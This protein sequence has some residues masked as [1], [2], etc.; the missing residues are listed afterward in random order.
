MNIFLDLF[1]H[2]QSCPRQIERRTLM[3][4][5]FTYFS[6][7]F[8]MNVSK[9]LFQN[10]EN[11]L[12]YRLNFIFIWWNL[13]KVFPKYL[14]IWK[15]NFSQKQVRHIPLATWS[16]YE[17]H[18][19]EKISIFWNT[20]SEHDIIKPKDPDRYDPSRPLTLHEFRNT[21]IFSF[22]F[23][24]KTKKAQSIDWAFVVLAPPYLP[25]QLPVEYFRHCIA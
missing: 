23:L 24:V 25:G 18:T 14:K 6:I 3:L 1:S 7:L 11:S 13:K 20:I 4:C 9:V 16:L 21:G 8:I 2:R 12:F 15:Q 22:E 19:D 5:I 10:R 17:D